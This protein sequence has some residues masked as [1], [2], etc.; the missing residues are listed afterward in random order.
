M[1]DAVAL[2]DEYWAHRRSTDQL[3]NVDRG[4]VEQIEHW[5]DLSPGGLAER[6]DRL[7][8]F[9]AAAEG[10]AAG[11]DLADRD[12][13]LLASVA[14]GARSAAVSL[15][16]LRDLSLVAGPF[17][18]PAILSI[19]V[20]SYVLVTRGHGEGYVAKLRSLPSFVDG[21]VAG[22]RDGVARGRVPT[23]RGVA[24]SIAALDTLL[25]RDPARDPLAGQ[26]PPREASEAQASAWRDDV[27]D[28][29][30]DVV[31][32]ALAALRDVLHGEVLPA[33][34]PDDEAGICHL[35]DGGPAYERLLWAS[36]STDL[37]AGEV[38][39]IGLERLAALDEEYRTVGT[40][41]FGTGDPAAVRDRLRR[42]PSLRY[43][44]GDEIVADAMATLARAE[45]EAPNWFPRRP[46]ARCTAFAVDGG[47]V[48]YY[49]GPSPDGARGGTFYFNTA[50]PAAWGRHNLEATTFHESVPGHHL[51]LALARELGLHPVLGEL[52]VVSHLEGWGLYAERL[53]DE[54][55]LYSS[56]LQ[57]L[58]M[59][60][61]DS[62]RAARLVV[63]TGLH[64][65]GWTRDRAVRFMVA[66]T[67]EERSVAEVEVDRYAADPGQATAYMVGRLE[68]ER[69]R[70]LAEDRL[71]GRFRVGDF[72][73][74][75]LGNG[76][77]PL[78]ELA[79]LV[80][81]W[82]DG[83]LRDGS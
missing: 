60:A 75:V 29:V 30:R 18:F 3:W 24:G 27:V 70:R 51:Q 71:G 19:L 49:T 9:A 36:T 11:G 17:D 6:I 69:L 83:A 26:A 56:P 35:P 1:S 41:A 58:G 12:R 16:W 77:V 55:G 45:A 52:E 31:R 22:L 74:V 50:D 57:R 64:A 38:H 47:A 80:E 73:D 53:A 67:A 2:A 5:D 39:R 65:M 32:P 59:L 72:H 66:N 33:A 62:L 14:F 28:A 10:L 76:M 37:P 23:A 54:M 34:R 21:W 43:A 78:P 68:I 44:T 61:L 46:V 82:I 81:A 63:D 7:T 48:A 13:T 25:A 40:A 79:R 20:P 8:A 15:P 4:D 42:D